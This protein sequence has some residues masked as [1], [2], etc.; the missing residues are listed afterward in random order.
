MAT[1]SLLI[2]IAGLVTI[3]LVAMRR[4]AAAAT[5][6]SPTG[7]YS[8]QVVRIA[9]AIARAEGFNVAGSKP[10]RFNNPCD[11]STPGMGVNQYATVEEGWNAA[12]RQ[13]NLMLMNQSG[14]YSPDMPII[15][16]ASLWTLGRSDEVDRP[17]VIGWAN[18]VAGALG[19]SVTDSL[20]MA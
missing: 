19:L 11:I 3:A 10:E 7:A 8:A 9:A 17:A 15:Q 6:T 4:T 18:T 13:V 2:T 20:E 5:I 14:I 16:I 12:Y 1:P